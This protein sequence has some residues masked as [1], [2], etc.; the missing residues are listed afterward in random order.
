MPQTEFNSPGVY[1]IETTPARAQEGISPAKMGIIGWTE[2]GPINTPIEVRS[3][4]D[5]TRYFGS[6]NSRGLVALCMRAF[7]GTGGQRAWVV[8][9]APSNAL[10]AS[11]DIDAVPGPTKWT[12]EANGPGLW[13]NDL[14]IRIEGNRNF[15]DRTPGAQAWTKFNLK[16]LQPTT[17]DPSIKAAVEDYEAI[18]FTDASASDYILAVMTDPRK[19]SLLTKIT[20]GAGGVPSGLLASQFTDINIGNGDGVATRFLHTLSSPTQIPV[21]AGTVRIVAAETQTDDQAQTPV[22]AVDGVASTF[23]ITLPTAPL[24]DGSVRLFYARQTPILG[25]VMPVVGAIDG[26]NTVFTVAASALAD[27]VHREN[28]IFRIRYAGALS[29][30]NNL[31]L[32]VPAAAHDLSTTPITVGL[33]IHPGTLSITV[34]IAGNPETITDDGAG[35]LS[36]T[37]GSLPGGG[38]INYDTGALTGTTAVL[39]ATTDITET[40]NTAQIITKAA[41]AD[42]LAQGVALTGAVT[43]GTIDLVDSVANPTGS[44]ALSFTTSVPPANGTAFY[45]DYVRLGVVSSSVGGTLS[46]DVGVGTNTVDFTT[47]NIDVTLAAP[48]RAGTTIDADYQTGQI[49]TDDGLGNLVGDVDAGGENKINYDTG[50][51]DVTFATAPLNG[52]NV[53]ANFTRLPNF[54]DYPL[55]GGTNGTAVTRAEISDPSLEPLR[56]GIYA[57]D[58]VEDPLNIVVPDFEGSAFV[59]ADVVDY[60]EARNTRF[61]ILGFANGTTEDE[62]IKYVLVDQ[63][64]DTKHAAIY[65][66]NVYFV[67]EVTQ[68][69]ELLPVTPF[70]AA[71]YAKTARN[72]NVGKSPAGIE[73]GALTANGIVGPEFDKKVN[74]IRVRDKLYQARINPL[75]N[76]DA[77]GFVVWGDKTLSN[78]FRWKYVNS[79]LLHN[80]LMDAL[81]RQL[82]WAVFENNGPALWLKIETAL[83]GFMG[84]LFRQGYFAGVT[85]QQAYFVVCNATNNN[86]ATIDEGRVIIDVGFTPFK[87]ANQIIFRLSQPASTITT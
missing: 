26:V 14:V 87:S 13:G 40:H 30:P 2:R 12:F 21:L 79:R 27:K 35:N 45:I 77:T 50:E 62:A 74:D 8:R 69:A 15:L 19:P 43:T 36:G 24:L 7:F 1:G 80:Y 17:F 47:G 82:H 85:E 38:T 83:K 33:P 39:D 5:F 11:V 48:A 29:G 42:N 41:S 78:E 16:V 68:R 71:V 84:S 53:L 61:A 49:V 75:Y 51:I 55:S 31:A 76:S 86:Q 25:A 65:W 37:N 18:Q 56:Q 32:N 67:N 54:V 73:D 6:I 20:A 10:T 3:V 58:D 44:G 63:A 72:K 46:G 9:V 70:I 23:A 64:W 34:T 66:P 60:C 28:T 4:I 81:S 57:F 59:Q 22:P 52:T